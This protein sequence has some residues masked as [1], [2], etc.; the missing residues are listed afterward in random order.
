ME[1][2]IPKQHPA[3]LYLMVPHQVNNSG[4]QGV[5]FTL[6]S[7]KKIKSFEGILPTQ[8]ILATHFQAERVRLKMAEE[9]NKAEGKTERYVPQPLY[10]E[11]ESSIF[12]AI[13]AE[14]K[15]KDSNVTGETFVLTLGGNFPCCLISV[16]KPQADKTVREETHKEEKAHD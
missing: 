2:K 1:E 6:L 16:Q 11:I 12:A 7:C 5:N 4:K 9:R 3:N 10:L 14:A 8:E 15:R 13:M